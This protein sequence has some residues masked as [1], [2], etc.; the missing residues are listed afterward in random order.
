MSDRFLLCSDRRSRQWNGRLYE[1][2]PQSREYLSQLTESIIA[3]YDRV[4]QEATYQE[5]YML[6]QWK[7]RR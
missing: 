5:N 2:V 4:M 6:S 7:F 1:S 3:P